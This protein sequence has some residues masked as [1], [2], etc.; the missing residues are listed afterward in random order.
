VK[1]YRRF[2]LFI[3]KLSTELIRHLAKHHA[4]VWAQP[5]HVRFNISTSARP[6]TQTFRRHWSLS[7]DVVGGCSHQRRHCWRHSPVD[8]MPCF[9]VAGFAA[10]SRG[11]CAAQRA[12]TALCRQSADSG[13]VRAV[14]GGS[15]TPSS[16]ISEASNCK[17]SV[18]SFHQMLL[19]TLVS[20][21]LGQKPRISLSF[22]LFAT[23]RVYSCAKL[24]PSTPPDYVCTGWGL[25]DMVRLMAASE[26][27]HGRKSTI[28]HSHV[29]I[30][31]NPHCSESTSGTSYC[32]CALTGTPPLPLQAS[33]R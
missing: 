29:K 24:V 10:A 18:Q 4:Q 7:P 20:A 2:R 8:K 25:P 12:A 9:A 1:T 22:L 6:E 26:R 27:S 21:C 19:C 28:S 5:H 23:M 13:P 14:S 30:S 32:S 16:H 15:N 3:G 17:H 31:R 11:N 33:C